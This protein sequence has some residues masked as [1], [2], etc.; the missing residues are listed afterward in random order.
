MADVAHWI[1]EHVLRR[2]DT[3]RREAV[4]DRDPDDRLVK[5]GPDLRLLGV[6]DQGMEARTQLA[7]CLYRGHYGEVTHE[8]DAEGGDTLRIDFGHGSFVVAGELLTMW[9]EPR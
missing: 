5:P 8:L 4:P 3:E 7:L 9:W 6:D 1:G 2:R